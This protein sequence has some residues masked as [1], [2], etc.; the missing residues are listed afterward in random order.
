[1]QFLIKNRKRHLKINMKK[2]S[3]H[4][5]KTIMRMKKNAR[6]NPNFGMTG[7]HHSEKTKE[8]IRDSSLGKIL[9]ATTKKRISISKI[10][11]IPWNKGQKGL[12]YQNVTAMHNHNAKYGVW[13]K[14]KNIYKN[15]EDHPMFGKHHSRSTIKKL[16]KSH[17]GIGH[18]DKTKQKMRLS[19][20]DY[21]KQ[22]CGGVMPMIGKHEAEILDKLEKI[23]GF[24]I[25]R[26][27]YIDGYYL[28]GYCQ[29]L[30]IAVEI[31]E[32]HH[33][34]NNKLKSKDLQRQNRIISL[35]NCKFLRIREKDY[36]KNNKLQVSEKML[37]YA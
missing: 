11:N 18:S 29:E 26:N 27:F 3:R 4:S 37:E 36:I 28:D 31:D 10:G 2:G 5:F 35:L 20:I 13:N 7:K 21:I 14:G 9:S 12:T 30:N 23:F 15:P 32:E 25:K 16:I 19:R 6:T 24:S 33:F 22:T 17:L 1:M 34:S 8:R